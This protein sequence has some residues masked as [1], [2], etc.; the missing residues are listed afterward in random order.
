MSTN[1]QTFINPEMWYFDVKNRKHC[2]LWRWLEAVTIPD[3]QIQLLTMVKKEWK[4]KTFLIK[5]L[6]R[7]VH[8]LL[9]H[10]VIVVQLQLGA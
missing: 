3:W 7:L 10:L 2:C 5:M 6:L 8:F 4:E 1:L 9:Q